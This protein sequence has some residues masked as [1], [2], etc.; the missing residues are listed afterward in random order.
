MGLTETLVEVPL[1]YL[2]ELLLHSIRLSL[3]NV[4]TIPSLIV[5]KP[6]MNQF[7]SLLGVAS[8]MIFVMR[9]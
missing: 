3:E 1:H 5:A 2:L 6:F 8:Q 9:Q 7:Q 4:P